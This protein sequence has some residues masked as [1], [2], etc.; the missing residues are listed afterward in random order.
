MKSRRV[1]STIKGHL[2]DR[3]SF[4]ILAASAFPTY[5]LASVSKVF[6]ARDQ[7]NKIYVCPPC[8]LNCDKLTFDKP[9][10][11]QVCGMTL[12]EKTDTKNGEPLTVHSL[13]ESYRVPGLSVAIIDNF[14]IVDTRVY[15]V[16]EA[17]SATPVTPGTLFQAGSV[18]KPVAA[19][20]ALRLVQAGKLSLDEDVNRK[21]KSWHVP[22]NEF[23]REQKVT[24]RRILSHSAGLTVHF[25]LGYAVGERLPT[26]S[27]ILDGKPPANTAP[28]RVD[29]IPGTRWRYSGGATLIEQQLMIDV[30]GERFPQLMREL[31][32]DPLGMNDTTYEQP[33]PPTRAKAAAS[34]TFASGKTVPG[35]WQVYPEMAAADWWTNPTDVGKRTIEI[36]GTIRKGDPIA[37]LDD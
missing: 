34:G 6:A 27:Q 11:C 25:F 19:V 15:G 22:E 33:L 17:G 21:L 29:F 23:T 10:T 37:P 13:M 18:S 24:L 20:G 3:R 9:G 8:G 26:L 7:T 32:F 14:K 5:K 1:K 28:V 12:I 35:N 31:V 30:T 4:V 36:G 16:T 2:L